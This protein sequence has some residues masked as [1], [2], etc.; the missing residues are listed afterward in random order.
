MFYPQKQV[1][2]LLTP[3]GNIRSDFNVKIELQSF[4]ANVGDS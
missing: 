1:Y 3:S 4:S 2:M